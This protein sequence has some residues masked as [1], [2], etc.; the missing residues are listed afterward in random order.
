MA[1]DK[2]SLLWHGTALFLIGLLT[3]LAEQHFTN[4]RMGLAAHLEGVMNGTFVLAVGAIWNEVWLSPR[5]KAVAYWTLLVGTYGNWIVTTL[6]AVLGTAALSPIT[7]VGHEAEPW[8]EAVITAGFAF[9]GLAIIA[10]VVLLMFGL[11]STAKPQ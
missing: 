7:A 10:A 2:R 11:R 4:V 5:T 1:D 8:K 6:A 9:I 3:G